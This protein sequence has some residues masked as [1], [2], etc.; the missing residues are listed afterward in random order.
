[1]I[2]LIS[3]M[4]KLVSVGAFA[5]AIELAQRASAEFGILWLLH[6]RFAYRSR[7]AFRGVE[8]IPST[9]AD[10]EIEWDDDYEMEIAA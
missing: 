5:Q 6:G 2:H 9:L 8:K 1:M 3:E 4:N 7:W 10:Q